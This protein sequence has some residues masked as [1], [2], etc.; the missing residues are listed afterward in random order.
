MR[1]HAEYIQRNQLE[2][3]IVQYDQHSVLFLSS[4][5]TPIRWKVWSC[6]WRNVDH[7]PGFFEFSCLTPIHNGVL[8]MEFS[9]QG[10]HRDE[11]FNAKRA[12]AWYWDQY[13][14]NILEI[15]QEAR[16][17]D[18]VAVSQDDHFFAAW[19]MFLLICDYALT[20]GTCTEFL[21]LVEE[22]VCSSLSR[23]E[24]LA[25]QCVMENMI[26]ESVPE[27]YRVWKHQFGPLVAVHSQ[28]LEKLVNG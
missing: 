2:M 10:V 11:C 16:R 15:I 27:A 6:Q 19:K 14:E 1:L 5:Y 4:T 25:R 23:V 18:F 24:R 13:E 9:P 8:P 21:S 28:W 3:P 7:H 12:M 20:H 17:Q 22:S 26:R